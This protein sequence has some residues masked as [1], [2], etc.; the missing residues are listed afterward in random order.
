MIKLTA[1]DGHSVRVFTLTRQQAESATKQVIWGQERLLI[2]EATVVIDDDTCRL[3]SIGED[4]YVH[5]LIYP[6]VDKEVAASFSI[7]AKDSVGFFTRY[8][9]AVPV[10]ET[11]FQFDFV[12]PGKAVLRFPHDILAGVDDVILRVDYVGDIGCAFIDGI[13]IHDNFYNGTC[14]EISLKQFKDHLLG[15]VMLLLISPI[16]E[17]SGGQRYVQTGMAF[18]PEIVGGGLAAIQKLSLMPQHRIDI[19]LL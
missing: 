9:I 1:A 6:N 7:L 19:H 14:W 3:Y 16:T 8:T 12:N 11:D 15:K 2:S 5:L 13:L 18:R 4:E 10:H 17:Q